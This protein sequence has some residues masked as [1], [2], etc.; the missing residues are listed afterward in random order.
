MLLQ[1]IKTLLCAK[2]D[3]SVL[4]IETFYGVDLIENG[5]SFHQINANILVKKGIQEIY[6]QS[7]V[8]HSTNLQ[9]D[10]FFQNSNLYSSTH[11][12]VTSICKEC[13]IYYDVKQ[14]GSVVSHFD[15][16]DSQS[17]SQIDC[18]SSPNFHSQEKYP[19]CKEKG[20]Q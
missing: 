8:V 20:R 18:M 5:K 3:R 19:E 16:G 2:C 1:N 11:T 12:H 4:G 9:L 17:Q 7:E 6:N 14:D 15:F 13:S 10:P